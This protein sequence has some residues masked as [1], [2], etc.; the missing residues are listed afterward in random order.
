M[1]QSPNSGRAVQIL[2]SHIQNGT[3]KDVLRDWK[4]IWSFSR[5][6]WPAIAAYTLFGL[7]SSGLSLVTGI[8]SKYMIDSI[9]AAEPEMILMLVGLLI[10]SAI[11]GVVFRSMTSRFSAKLSITM[12]H[13]VQSFVFERLIH[14]DWMAISRYSTGDLLNRFSGD[15]NTVSN[16]AVS[17]LP[18][19][20]IQAFTVLAT[21]AVI[22]YYDPV[23]ALIGC[24]S[25][26]LLFLVSR[27]LMS[28]QRDYNR[29]MRQVSSEISA[30][31]SETFRNIDTL[32]GFG[33]ED[34]VNDQL[35]T[36]QDRY[37]DVALE[38]NR[39]SVNTNAMLTAMS[40]LVQY[41][42]LGYCLWQLW[43][44]RILFGTMVLFLQQRSSLQAAFSSLISQVPTALSGSIAT[45]RIRELT[46]LDKEPRHNQA[47][48]TERCRIHVE[49]VHVSYD[50]D[51][52]VLSDISFRVGPGEAIA[53]VGPSGEGK[54]TLLR[55]LLGLV[56]PEEGTLELITPDGKR[57]PIDATTR[58]YFSY[59]PQGN[60]LLAG[61]VA[62]NLRLAK[63]DATDEEMIR[64]LDDACAWEFVSKMPGG[65]H[66]PLGEGGKG[67]SEGQAQRIA[68]ARALMRKTPAILLDEVTSALDMD[69]ERRVLNHL[70]NLGITVI[71]TT[72]R[73]SVLNMCT[74]AYRVKDHSLTQLTPEE[75]RELTHI[76]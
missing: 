28:R 1:Q 42:A 62:D 53:L 66:S 71:V 9:M 3:L 56:R 36:W 27:R 24:I 31:Q 33:V 76:D 49:K 26:P 55:L 68:I 8:V 64:A 35:H 47:P 2:R 57:R 72:H 70:M 5:A 59:V 67:L 11:F 15:I 38:Y 44:G 6:H 73:P 34:S 20:I 29:R 69:T 30:F 75:V 10:G 18:N 14:S 12:Q 22:I 37:R 13:T 23:M 52:R 61:T 58:K 32:K 25:V 41:A 19:V 74:R 39:F 51:R 43:E 45:E 63:P 4:W 46:E 40:T 60:T 54:T 7:A 17:W 16:C 65:I 50:A 21:L 48:P